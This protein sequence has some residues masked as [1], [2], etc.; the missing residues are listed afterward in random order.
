MRV[1][2]DSSTLCAKRKN[3]RTKSKQVDWV[4]AP[5]QARVGI[6][7]AVSIVH[8]NA[9]KSLSKRHRA[10]PVLT[11]AQLLAGDIPYVMNSKKE[12]THVVL[13]EYPSVCRRSLLL[14]LLLYGATCCKRESV[15]ECPRGHVPWQYNPSIHVQKR[16]LEVK[17]ELKIKERTRGRK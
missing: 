7:S 8:K 17:R 3:K 11:L 16:E 4:T 13:A 12:S 10:W 6:L 1:Y 2:R 5:D 14:S 9:G 15:G